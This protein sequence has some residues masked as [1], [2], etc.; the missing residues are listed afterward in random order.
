MGLTRARA[1]AFAFVVREN[2]STYVDEKDAEAFAA[3]RATREPRLARTLQSDEIDAEGVRVRV[4][5]MKSAMDVP[6]ALRALVRAREVEFTETRRFVSKRANA[7]EAEA[8]AEAEEH[9]ETFT[10]VNNISDRARV[11]GV[12]VV[13]ARSRDECVVEV[14]GEC[15]VAIRV[16]GD[17]A[18]KFIIR[19]LREAYERV[20]ELFAEFVEYKRVNGMKCEERKSSR[21]SSAG[22]E[23]SSYETA[24]E[25]VGSATESDDA[26]R[27]SDLAPLASVS[28][29]RVF[30]CCASRARAVAGED[31]EKGAR[32]SRANANG[33]A[34]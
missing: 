31:E 27:T 29:V 10:T 25:S 30:M 4:M 19:G 26:G 34:S 7:T 11:D 12:V 8:E 3:F 18:E 22:S 28:K 24:R 13:R 9:V 1:F 32:K 5:T 23:A 16:V 33:R 15:Q 20:P 21:A 14:S 17:V 2:K 6:R